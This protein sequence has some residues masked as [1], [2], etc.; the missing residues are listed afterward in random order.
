MSGQQVNTVSGE[1]E[2][3]HHEAKIVQVVIAILCK[4]ELPRG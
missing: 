3:D 4:T 1:E 2:T